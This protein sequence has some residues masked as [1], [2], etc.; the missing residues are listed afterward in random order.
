MKVTPLDLI[1]YPSL[2]G[3]TLGTILLCFA[4]AALN[5]GSVSLLDKMGFNVF[6]NNAGIGIVEM[7]SLIP[8]LLLINDLPR[9][10]TLQVSLGSGAVLCLIMI[11]VEHDPN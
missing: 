3:I 8:V 10:S 5:F 4:G 2:R 1:R 9:K 6:V 7:T 11:F